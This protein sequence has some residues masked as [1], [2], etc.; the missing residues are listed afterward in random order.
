MPAITNYTRQRILFHHFSGKAAP[1]I[2]KLLF[3]EEKIKVTRVA[4]WKFLCRYYE[5][6]STSRRP[7]R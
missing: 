7:G 1:T 5:L 6:G 3:D 2:A 4:I